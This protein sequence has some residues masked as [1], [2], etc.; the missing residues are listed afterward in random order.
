MTMRDSG[1]LIASGCSRRMS[2]SVRAIWVVAQRPA[3]W[4]R[5]YHFSTVFMAQEYRELKSLLG[6][7]LRQRCA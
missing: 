2:S 1:I 3:H 7:L 5:H 6:S 4:M